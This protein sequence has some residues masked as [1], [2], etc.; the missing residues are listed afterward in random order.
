M[1]GTLDKWRFTIGRAKYRDGKVPAFTAQIDTMQINIVKSIRQIY[2]KGV[3]AAMNENGRAYTGV[4]KYKKSI[5]YK[6]PDG[7]EMLTTAEY[8]QL[9][10][11]FFAQEIEEMDQEILEEVDKIL[12]ETFVSAEALRREFDKMFYDKRLIRQQERAAKRDA[13]A[14]ER[15]ARK[16][17]KKKS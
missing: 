15:E 2:R 9:D 11:L 1:F 5:G 14:A 3:K 17:E 8:C 12:D 7:D 16:A 4:E 13:R 10:S 6:A